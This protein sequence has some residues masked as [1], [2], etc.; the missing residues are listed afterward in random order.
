MFDLDHEIQSWCR[1]VSTSVWGRDARIEELKDH[2]YCEVEKLEKSGLSPE[3]AFRQATEGMGSVEELA[4]EYSK[5]RNAA[6]LICDKIQET[7]EGLEQIGNAMS[8]KKAAS[9]N[10]LVSLLFA[11]AI[12]LASFFL[13]DSQYAQHA[14]VVTFSLIAVWFI[15]FSILSSAG[16][17]QCKN[18]TAVVD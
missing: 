16:A 7:E 4:A 11:A 18:K 6:N 15:P 8:P 1:S 13:K 17:K 9:L 2:L 14:D 12:L 5:N 10:I 3:Q